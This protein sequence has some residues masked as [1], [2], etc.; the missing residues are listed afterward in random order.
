MRRVLACLALVAAAG[1]VLQAEDF[2]EKKKFAEWSDKEVRQMI[3][4]S[5]WARRVDV[6][7][8]G[9]GEGAGG[10]RGG[11]RGGGMG[12]GGGFPAGG[13]GGGEGGIE[14]GGGGGGGAVGP[15]SG[16]SQES[17]SVPRLPVLIRW[18]SA[19]PVKQAI[20]KARMGA[21]AATSQD[22]AKVLERQEQYYVIAL[23]GIP[24]RMLMGGGPDK[25]KSTIALKIAKLPPVAPLDVKVNAGQGMAEVYLLF[26]RSQPDAHVITLDDKEVELVA[27]IGPLDVRRK[28]RLKDMVFEGKLEL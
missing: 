2:W 8:G 24:A 15:S 21:E 13:G 22:A 11:R 1:L 27:Q 18:Q 19:L 25:L 9:M 20:L 16:M 3:T 5:P 23:S 6:A 10:G 4:N 12:G 17:T 26:P 7:L 28:F 14:G